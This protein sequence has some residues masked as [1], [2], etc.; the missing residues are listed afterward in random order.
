MQPSRIHHVGVPVSDLGLSVAVPRSP[1]KSEL[2]A[3]W[4][5][6]LVNLHPIAGALRTQTA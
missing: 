5:A 2:Q 4:T 1:K 6:V 3:V